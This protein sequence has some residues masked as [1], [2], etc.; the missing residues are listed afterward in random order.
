MEVKRAIF[1]Y[2]HNN[3][4]QKFAVINPLIH[5]MEMIV[6]I[7]Y[8]V[9]TSQLC[10]LWFMCYVWTTGGLAEVFL[11]VFSVKG[12]RIYKMTTTDTYFTYTER[13]VG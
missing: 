10:C 8:F 11:L 1:L 13:T 2:L 7:L 3:H 4:L 9:F 5:S 12:N 6:F